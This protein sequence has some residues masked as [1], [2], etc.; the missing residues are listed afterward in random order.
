[1][2]IH[3]YPEEAKSELRL[4]EKLVIHE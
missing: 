3:K 4:K 2:P 1:V